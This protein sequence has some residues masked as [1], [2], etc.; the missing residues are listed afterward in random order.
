LT[1]SRE[2]FGT[3]LLRGHPDDPSSSSVTL[4]SAA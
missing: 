1:S 4:S 2:A 3:W